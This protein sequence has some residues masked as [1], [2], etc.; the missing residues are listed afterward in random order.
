MNHVPYLYDLEFG[1]FFFGRPIYI[2]LWTWYIYSLSTIEIE[3]NCLPYSSNHMLLG[4]W[5]DYET[6][7]FH[8]IFVLIY[9][10]LIIHSN[11][12]ILASDLIL[13]L[14]L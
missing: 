9:L 13:Q 4:I 7:L 1:A 12:Y 2:F 6:F 8:L 11:R 5:M 10:I 14:L 3:E